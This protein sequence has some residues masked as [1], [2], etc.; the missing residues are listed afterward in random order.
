MEHN[1]I[2]KQFKDELLKRKG[3]VIILPQ[4][5]VFVDNGIYDFKNVT[6]F[7]DW[8]ISDVHVEID[9]SKCTTT[10]YQAISII[11]L[12][13][14]K[15]KSQ[16][17]RVVFKE[18]ADV[19]GASELFRRLGGRGLFTVFTHDN[20]NFK[21]DKYKPL[22]AVRNPHDFK[23]VIEAADSYTQGFNVEFTKTLR[24]VLSELLYNTLEH[25][26]SFY[27]FGKRDLLI[28]SICQFTWY[29]RRNELQFIIGDAGIGIKKHLEQSYPGQ[30]SDQMAILKA[31]EPQVSGTF[32]VTDIYSQKNNAGIGLFLSTNIIRRL[33]ADMH[34]LSGSGVVHISPRD[35]TSSEIETPWPGTLVVV[36][37]KLDSNVEIEF[38]HK[39]MQEFRESALKEQKKADKVESEDTFYMEIRNYFGSYAED[40]EA[41]IKFR[42]DKLFV[43]VKAG[44]RVVINFDGV[45]SAPHSFLSA[46]FAS[47]IKSVGMSAYKQFKFINANSEIRETIDFI[48]DENTD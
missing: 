39:M 25:G 9:L 12:Y 7:F 6:N 1:D 37:L 35:I 19:N 48:L 15:L 21:G 20:I 13:A 46:L 33:N 45:E 3:Q 27:K 30:E 2:L 4:K 11:I 28:P 41:A 26:K 22:F 23:K 44:K 38:L 36:T 47:P 5:F 32:S 10:N 18:S 40:K 42:D 17:C 34:I 16:K 31:M 29:A 43:Q 24:Y 14:W 8:S